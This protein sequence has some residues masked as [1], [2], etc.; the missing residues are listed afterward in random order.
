M[1]DLPFAHD[2]G[3]SDAY[4]EASEQALRFAQM[5]DEDL[6]WKISAALV[7]YKKMKGLPAWTWTVTLDVPRQYFSIHA[8]TGRHRYDICSLNKD[9]FHWTQ[10]K[11]E[12]WNLRFSDPTH[13]SHQCHLSNPNRWEADE[14]EFAARYLEAAAC[15]AWGRTLTEGQEKILTAMGPFKDSQY[16][17]QFPRDYSTEAHKSLMGTFLRS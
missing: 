7:E 15:Q 2:S 4:I 5:H 9:S 16:S 3:Y 6:A 8:F 12:G 17:K 11:G 10:F 14:F 13:Q 1:I